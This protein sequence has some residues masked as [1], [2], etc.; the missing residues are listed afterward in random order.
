M[1]SQYSRAL[2][3]VLLAVATA[4]GGRLSSND[5]LPL[6]PLRL[7]PQ[8]SGTTASLRGIS[9]AS[10]RVAWASGTRGTFLRTSDGGVTWQVGRVAGAESLDFRDVHAVDSTTAYLL[11]IQKPA[12][13]YKTTDAGRSWVRQ[14]ADSSADAFIDCLAF[15]DRDHGIAIGDP[16]A[17]LDGKMMLLVTANG[18]ATWEQ[19]PRDRLPVPLPKEG[20]F[21]A[22]GTCITVMGTANAWIGTGL[23]GKGRVFRTS[24]RGR[25]WSVVE[26]PVDASV[27]T[28]G[29]FT[30]AFRDADNGI[31][32]GGDYQR[33]TLGQSNY[34]RTEDGGRTWQAATP[35]PGFFIS[36]VAYVGGTGGRGVVAVGTAGWT[37][38]TDGGETW[39]RGDTTSLNAVAF[40]GRTGWAVGP[41]GRVVKLVF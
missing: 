32:L 19:V 15:W 37:S 18:G 39:V 13:I 35:G 8:A 4:C 3:P 12:S 17:A 36:G 10:E 25:T 11:G 6:G 9:A 40:A 7:E 27:G 16:M 31:V 29:I 5:A 38:S 30:I 33:P 28:A 26:T 20:A 24:D 41:S 1:T 2:V 34:A 14:F 21:A 23:G 22:S